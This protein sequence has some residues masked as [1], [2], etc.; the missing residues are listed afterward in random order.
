MKKLYMKSIK[1]EMSHFYNSSNSYLQI[2]H[3]RRENFFKGYLRFISQHIASLNKN[4]KLK[5]LELG[6]GDGYSTCMIAKAFPSAEVLGTDISKKFIKYAKSNFKLKNLDYKVEDSTRLSFKD[7]RFDIITSQD[8][9]EHVPDIES[10]LKESDRVLKKQ[11]LI[12]IISPNVISPITP[13][14]DLFLLRTRVAYTLRI[15][16]NIGLFFRNLNLSLKKLF[17]QKADFIYEQPDLRNATQIGGD[18][19]RVYLANPIDLIKYFKNNQNY[20]IINVNNSTSLYQKILSFFLKPFY[21][22]GFVAKKIR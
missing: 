7:S 14:I 8:V 17:S 6:C 11:G 1:K 5:I 19:D 16:D 3:S 10:F 9:I 22:I 21:S 18:L 12:I 15:Q 13:L 4:N 20:K 2:L